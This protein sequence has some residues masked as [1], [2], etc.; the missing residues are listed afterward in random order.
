MEELSN[1]LVGRSG[2]FEFV[3][4]LLALEGE[5]LADGHHVGG[6]GSG[7]IRANDGGAAQGFDGWQRPGV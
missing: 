2:D 4:L 3:K 7:L 5:H 1:W 6:Q